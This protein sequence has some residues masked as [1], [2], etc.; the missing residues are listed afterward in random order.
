MFVKDVL[1]PSLS[2]TKE[3]HVRSHDMY[4]TLLPLFN[5]A[6]SNVEPSNAQVEARNQPLQIHD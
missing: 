6:H 4:D 1:Q 3:T 2:C 5:G